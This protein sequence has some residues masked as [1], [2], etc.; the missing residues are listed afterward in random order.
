MLV[1]SGNGG[2]GVAEEVNE[3]VV[4]NTF[5]MTMHGQRRAF[6][7]SPLDSFI[8]RAMFRERAGGT[9]GEIENRRALGNEFFSKRADKVFKGLVSGRQKQS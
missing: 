8:N 5:E 4:P 6:R 3:D 2:F 1:R 9:A 7:V